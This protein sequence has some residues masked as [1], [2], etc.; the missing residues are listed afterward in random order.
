MIDK[1][2]T[3]ASVLFVVLCFNSKHHKK[4]T[5]KDSNGNIIATVVKSCAER[6]GVLKINTDDGTK[7]KVV[8]Q[9][10]T[11]TEDKQQE[12]LERYS[13]YIPDHTLNETVWHYLYYKNNHIENSYIVFFNN[14][15]RKLHD[16]TIDALLSNLGREYADRIAH[17]YAYLASNTDYVIMFRVHYW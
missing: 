2:L 7:E 12:I 3:F 8:Y 13:K 11:L 17:S 9:F 6:K 4:Q 10:V 15:L 1:I 16:S 5:I 14:D